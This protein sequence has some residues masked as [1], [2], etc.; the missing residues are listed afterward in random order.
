MLAQAPFLAAE[1]NRRGPQTR[2]LHLN[3]E[4][5]G[6]SRDH[7]TMAFLYV[8]YRRSDPEC[9][10][11]G[12]GTIVRFRWN[13]KRVIRLDPL[14]PRA[15]APGAVAASEAGVKCQ[16]GRLPETVWSAG[17]SLRKLAR[18]AVAVGAAVEPQLR[19]GAGHE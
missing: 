15:F 8:L 17:A 19:G 7:K 6:L 13:G 11:T 10:P 9:C 3:H 1:D 4:V 2:S 14:P 5:I 16:N 18:V 12:G